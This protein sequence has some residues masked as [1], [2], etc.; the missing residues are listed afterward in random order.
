MIYYKGGK[1][2]R[3]YCDCCKTL[4]P[5]NAYVW[6]SKNEEL[7]ERCYRFDQN[8]PTVRDYFAQIRAD[9]LPYEQRVKH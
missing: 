4:I 1:P 9:R 8:I 2:D 3:C 6:Q 7:C 5:E